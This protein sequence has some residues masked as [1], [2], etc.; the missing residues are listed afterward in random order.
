MCIER[1]NTAIH[2]ATLVVNNAVL[3][4]L[5]SVLTDGMLPVL[6]GTTR[7]EAGEV[8]ETCFLP[9]PMR[10]SFVRS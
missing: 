8:G 3:Q 6:H 7:V 1:H 4:A 10:K 9:P 5:R 2:I